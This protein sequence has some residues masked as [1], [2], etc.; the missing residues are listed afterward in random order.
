MDRLRQEL[1]RMFCRRCDYCQPCTQEI[2]ISLAMDYPSLVKRL[3]P[4]IIF[5]GF[6]ADAMEKATN[7][8]KC[9]DCEE[10]CPYNLPIQEMLEDY[11]NWY[12]REKTKYQGQTYSNKRI[13]SYSS[14]NGIHP[15]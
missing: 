10:R 11:V 3:P 2:P 14:N 6:V 4:E 13:P 12:R 8:T 1:G 5:S 15:G 9:G 7:C